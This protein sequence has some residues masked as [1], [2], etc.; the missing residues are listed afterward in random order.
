[1]SLRSLVTFLVVFK[2]VCMVNMGNSASTR[3]TRDDTFYND[4]NI[5]D[6]SISCIKAHLKSG[7]P[8]KEFRVCFTCYLFFFA[9]YTTKKAELLISSPT[10]FQIV[11][12]TFHFKHQLCFIIFRCINTCCKCTIITYSML[13]DNPPTFTFTVSTLYCLCS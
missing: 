7:R 8:A 6:V 13:F 2:V 9:F 12:T 11:N 5:S 10:R 4:N 1:M 3:T